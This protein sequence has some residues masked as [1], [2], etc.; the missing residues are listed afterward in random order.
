MELRLSDTS[1]FILLGRQYSERLGGFMKAHCSVI[2][3][4][5]HTVILEY[6]NIKE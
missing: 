3:V 4:K 6:F 5:G 2:S 1:M